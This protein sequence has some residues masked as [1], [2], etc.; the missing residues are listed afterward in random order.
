MNDFALFLGKFLRQGTAIASISP[1]SRWL[2]AAALRNIDWEHARVLVEL[3][4]APDPLHERSASVSG[5][6]AGSS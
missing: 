2:S 1:S 5:R 3:A 6:T 4:R